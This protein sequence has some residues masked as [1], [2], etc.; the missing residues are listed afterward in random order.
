[1]ADVISAYYENARLAQAAYAANL[2]PGM[3]PNSYVQ[4]LQAGGMSLSQTTGFVTDYEILAP[5]YTDPS[6]G[7]AATLLQNKATGEK[8]LAIRGTEPSDLLDWLTDV[9]I[10]TGNVLPILQGQYQSLKSYYQQLLVGGQLTAAEAFTVTG[11]SLGGFL[12]QLFAVGNSSVVEH[13]YTY[14]APGIG[15]F[16]AQLGDLFGIINPNVSGANI[17]NLQGSGPSATAGWGTL[18][19]EVKSLYTE[20]QSPNYIA[21]HFIKYPADSL[22]VYSLFAILDPN[23]QVSTI[24]AILKAASNKDSKTLESTLDSLRTL[25]QE[26]FSFGTPDTNAMPTTIDDRDSFYTNLFS[27]QRYIENLPAYDSN[28][29]SLGFSVE[30]LVGQDTTALFNSAQTDI[31]TRYALYKLNPFVVRNAADLY[32]AINNSS[33]ALDIYN[34]ATS[35]GSLTEQYFKD[36]SAFLVNK[37]WSATN[38]KTTFSG[39]ALALRNSGKQYF[40]DRTSGY[41]LYL[42]ED[43][44][45]SDVPT[46]SLTQIVFGS[47]NA[48][49]ITGGDKWDK[50]YGMA[51]DNNRGQTTVL[52]GCN[53]EE[54][55]DTEIPYAPPCASGPG[56]HPLAHHPARQ[57]PQSLF[58]RRRR[59]SALSRHAAGTV[60]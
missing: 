53:P 42:G 26:N 33:G 31:A 16:V 29:K 57:Q 17:T 43:R 25:F 48:D 41:R 11:H 40:D 56:R 12:A 19:G 13:A 39:D 7:F 23:A 21:N 8:V 14:N 32:N 18:I 36:R 35:T 20:N 3:T 22:A 45:A 52:I 46:S 15:G 10:F 59:L 44:F 34:P 60:P 5:T 51:G 37:I 1:M 38:D 6:N 27:L 55:K 58:L 2:T 54:Q 50:L 28:T 49:Q 24:T 30:S 9:S 47:E 4:A